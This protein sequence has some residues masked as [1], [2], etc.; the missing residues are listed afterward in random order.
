LGDHW[1]AGPSALEL[2]LPK[3]PSAFHGGGVAFHQVAVLPGGDPPDEGFFDAVRRRVPALTGVLRGPGGA[4]FGWA[5]D[6]QGR[7]TQ[8]FEEI[9]LGPQPEPR[10]Y[11]NRRGVIAVHPTVLADDLARLHTETGAAD[12]L[13]ALAGL[14]KTYP[15]HFEGH[16]C[17]A[18]P[19]APGADPPDPAAA[20][21]A[22][23]PF[24]PARH[25]AAVYAE[26]AELIQD[27]EAAVLRPPSPLQPRYNPLL[28]AA[29][30]TGKTTLARALAGGSGYH[31]Y[32][33]ARESP[34]A[35][36]VG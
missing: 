34:P 4:P 32:K 23:R 26:V 33:I 36:A 16:R 24:K 11:G 1:L 17:F 21:S 19:S 8:G 29:S 31:Y 9:R 3:A 28:I 5:T 22:R 13:E 30:G 18:L 2:Y 35:L 27:H 14:L 6:P 15:Q 25:Q 10:R 12:A 20:R 7:E